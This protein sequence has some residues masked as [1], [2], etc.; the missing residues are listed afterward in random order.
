MDPTL[1]EEIVR[2]R[3][4]AG[5]CDGSRDTNIIASDYD[6]IMTMC[7]RIIEQVNQLL[8]LCHACFGSQSRPC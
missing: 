2:C 6:S 5:D 3:I 4:I 1:G 7:S 8:Q